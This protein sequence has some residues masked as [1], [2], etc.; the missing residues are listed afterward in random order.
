MVINAQSLCLSFLF[1]TPPLYL[2]LT[3]LS[4]SLSLFLRPPPLSFILPLRP[5]SFISELSSVNQKRECGDKQWLLNF[6]KQSEL[7]KTRLLSE[8]LN[9]RWS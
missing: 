9:S 5:T 2:P 8:S 1:P 4:L 3:S 6:S 7:D